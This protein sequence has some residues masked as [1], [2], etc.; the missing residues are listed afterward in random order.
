MG[1]N[2]PD[3][4]DQLP[5]DLSDVEFFQHLLAELHDDLDAKI[6]RLRIL[7][8]VDREMGLSG[9]LI[10]GGHS[11]FY[12]WL[13]ARSSFAHGNFAGTILLCQGLVEHLLAA[14][15]HSALLTEDVPERVTF[16]ETLRRCREMNVISDQDLADLQNLIGLR[17]PLSHFRHMHDQSNLDRRSIT[18]GQYVHDLLRN[19][20]EFAIGAVARILRKSPFKIE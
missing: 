14:F 2:G 3:Q 4:P 1:E 10:F 15:L 16:R 8:K 18:T 6:A 20:A 7:A 11:A 17:N 12:S 9:T 5:A 19:D 13:E